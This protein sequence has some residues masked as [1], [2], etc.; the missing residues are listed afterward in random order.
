MKQY[1][2]YYLASQVSEKIC[3]LIRKYL[4]KSA[5]SASRFTAELDKIPDG[6]ILHASINFSIEIYSYDIGK[7]YSIV[8][9][10]LS[11]NK[12]NRL[13]G[14]L[15]YVENLGMYRTR[16]HRSKIGDLLRD[17]FLLITL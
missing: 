10:P 9:C 6:I 12:E 15:E 3:Y 17:L 1:I 16:A 14:Y 13:I 5:L 8:F 2:K 7:S 11:R 4:T